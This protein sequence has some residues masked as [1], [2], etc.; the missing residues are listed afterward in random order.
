M[1]KANIED[2]YADDLQGEERFAFLRDL[3]GPLVALFVHG[4][5][6]VEVRLQQVGHIDGA[7]DATYPLLY[8]ERWIAYATKD[9]VPIAM[10]E[11]FAGKADPYDPP[12]AGAR[13]IG[14][15]ISVDAAHLN[16]G[17]GRGMVASLY[18]AGVLIVPSGKMTVAGAALFNALQASGVDVPSAGRITCPWPR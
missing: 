14:A 10:Y 18:D 11:F 3:P 15:A 2:R 9:G 17:I 16:V 8:D 6:D 13:L 1:W 5:R 12:V 7:D 4:K